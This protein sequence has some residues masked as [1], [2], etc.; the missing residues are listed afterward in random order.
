M[1]SQQRPCSRLPMERGSRGWRSTA[2]RAYPCERARLHARDSPL[3][4]ARASNR[5]VLGLGCPSFGDYSAHLLVAE[6][7]SVDGIDALSQLRTRLGSCIACVEHALT[8][9]AGSSP[10]C[11]AEAHLTPL[12]RSRGVPDHPR[13]RF[14]PYAKDETVLVG[15][16][17]SSAVWSDREQVQS[18]IGAFAHRS[19]PV[20]QFVRHLSPHRGMAKGSGV[21]LLCSVWTQ[22]TAFKSTA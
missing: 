2:P 18:R 3:P 13:G 20:R 14:T 22:Q 11:G 7:A 17:P 6:R 8:S 5:C 12:A 19:S 21:A 10:V 16:T 1:R 9:L 15:V 4:H